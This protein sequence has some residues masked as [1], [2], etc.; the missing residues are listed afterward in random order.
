MDFTKLNLEF[1][2]MQNKIIK[3][4]AINL[5][6]NIRIKENIKLINKYET[7]VKNEKNEFISHLANVVV[8]NAKVENEF[9]R[10]LLELEEGKKDE[11]GS[12]NK[13]V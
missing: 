4:E 9:L 8:V 1:E 10:G 2:N 5:A 12:K 6:I 11:Q 3:L 7:K 13:T